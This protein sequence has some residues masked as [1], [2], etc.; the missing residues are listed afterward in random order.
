M[1]GTNSEILCF[2]S[3]KKNKKDWIDHRLNRYHQR[4]TSSKS[5]VREYS[6]I[7]FFLKICV[8]Y[9][10]HGP[11]INYIILVEGRPFNSDI[12]F[13]VIFF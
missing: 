9:V 6:S 3:S 7:T 13:E 5:A 11:S 12:E 2:S 10:I 8:M 4:L 1:L